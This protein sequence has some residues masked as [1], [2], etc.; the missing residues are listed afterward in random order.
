MFCIRVSSRYDN[1]SRAAAL[2]TLKDARD[3][4][5]KAGSGNEQT[6]AHRANLV[7]LID[8]ALVIK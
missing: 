2:N 7:Y 1:A 5:K 4:L 8:T 6:K 3:K